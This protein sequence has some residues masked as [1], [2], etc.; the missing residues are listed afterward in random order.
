MPIVQWL[1]EEPGKYFP[2]PV[3]GG[4]VPSKAQVCHRQRLARSAKLQGLEQLEKR[5]DL[6]LTGSP[7]S[8]AEG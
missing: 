6:K 2:R 1:R 5:P 4:L 8:E 3:S 7:K